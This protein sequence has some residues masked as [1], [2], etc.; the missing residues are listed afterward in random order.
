MSFQERS[1][2]AAK[3]VIEALGAAPDAAQGE[4]VASAIEKAI[5]EAVAEANERCSTVAQQ[6]CS[7]DKDLAHKIANR[8]KR[9]HEALVA[10]LSALR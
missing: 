2:T 6:C 5:I 8:I 9:E 7:A 3:A 10:N 1:E 4:A